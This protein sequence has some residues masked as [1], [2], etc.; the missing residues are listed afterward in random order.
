LSENLKSLKD[1][2]I[3]FDGG[4]KPQIVPLERLYPPPT[5][6]KREATSAK[7]W[8]KTCYKGY[9]IS[10]LPFSSLGVEGLRCWVRMATQTQSVTARENSSPLSLFMGALPQVRANK[11]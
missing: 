6:N 7:S 2:R 5:R 9:I 8:P 4:T 3:P 1:S 10:S 11:T